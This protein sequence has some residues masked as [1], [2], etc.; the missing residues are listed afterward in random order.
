MKFG[1]DSI[2]LADIER[3]TITPRESLE[4]YTYAASSSPIKNPGHIF[5]E[6]QKNFKHSI[7]LGDCKNWFGGHW[8]SGPSQMQKADLPSFAIIKYFRAFGVGKGR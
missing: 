4:S 8:V 6:K 5:N 1:Y 3:I 2:S 7:L